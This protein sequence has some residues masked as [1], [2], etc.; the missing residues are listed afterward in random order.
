MRH[1]GR[2]LTAPATGLPDVGRVPILAKSKAAWPSPGMLIRASFLI[3]TI[4][5]WVDEPSVNSIV[6]SNRRCHGLS[7]YL[8]IAY[9]F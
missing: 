4:L 2:A 1:D 7:D 3:V 5:A 6:I 8:T 9:G